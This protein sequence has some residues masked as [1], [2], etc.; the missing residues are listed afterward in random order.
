MLSRLKFEITPL[1]NEIL[2][3]LPVSVWESDTTTFFDP[4]MGGGQFI[5]EVVARLQK[6]GWSDDNISTRVWGLADTPLSLNFVKHKYKIPGTFS[7][8]GIEEME[9]WINMGKKFDVVLGNPPFQDGTKE[10]NGGLHKL[11]PK[12]ISLGTQITINDGFVCM[13]T[14]TSGLA[15][16]N[17]TLNT[18]K[19]H[20]L[21][22][23]SLN[24]RKHFNGVGSQFSWWIL[25]IGKKGKTNI[26]GTLY[27]IS[28]LEYFPPNP[29][30]FS[31]HLKV[32]LSGQYMHWEVERDQSTNCVYTNSKPLFMSRDKTTSHLYPIFHTN[33]QT[34]W[35]SQEPKDFNEKKVIFTTSGYAKAHYDNGKE[36][37]TSTSRY[38][39]VKTDDAGNHLVGVFN[40][41][42]YQFIMQ[43]AKWNGFVNVNVIK[44]LPAV[45]L[46]RSWTD[47][48]LYTHFNL[49]DE[50]IALI[51]STIK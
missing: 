31:I 24:V 13:V 11:W 32:M 48:E 37:T 26:D 30:H 23:M 16:N 45:D 33:N 2:D 12:F 21:K 25:Q 46:S 50:E 10:G 39:K 17:E 49:T 5:K 40:S 34:L 19:T 6:Y 36:G 7:V 15:P 22:E 47:T 41:K 18:F 4:A 38:I 20:H 3:R 44:L 1:V 28:A 8:G 43:T 9:K 35:L 27:D 51:E 29:D 14:P 42:L